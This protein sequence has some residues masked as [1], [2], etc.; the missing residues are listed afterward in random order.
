MTMIKYGALAVV[1]AAGVSLAG[2]AQ[3]QLLDTAT[4]INVDAGAGS[5]GTGVDASTDVRASSTEDRAGS[6]MS[7]ATG[8]DAQPNGSAGVAG[9]L[10]FSLNKRAMSDDTEY[11]V[12]D[13]GAVQTAAG[14]ESYAATSMRDDERLESV[15]LEDGT[16]EMTYRVD[17]RFLGFI[18]GSMDVR[19]TVT[20]D[21]TVDVRYPWY[22]FLMRASESRADLEARVASE[23]EAIADDFAEASAGVSADTAE[24]RRWALALERMRMSLYATASAEAQR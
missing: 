1:L 11:S 3:A 22:A 4:G 16:L 23:Q 12:T 9:T 10:G 5:N 18:P 19:A 2:S 20:A 6:D 8:T 24:L 17:A 15:R 21:G 7:A 13:A 14:L